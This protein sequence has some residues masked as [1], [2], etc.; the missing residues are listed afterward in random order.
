[1]FKSYLA[2]QGKPDRRGYL[3]VRKA[4]LLG[5]Q[6]GAAA[7][8][9]VSFTPSFARRSMFGVLKM[10]PTL[11]GIIQRAFKGMRMRNS[12]LILIF[13]SLF[14]LKYFDFFYLFSRR[15]MIFF[16]FS[17]NNSYLDKFQANHSLFFPKSNEGSLQN[18]SHCSWRRELMPWGWCYLEGWAMQSLITRLSETCLLVPAGWDSEIFAGCWEC[19]HQVWFCSEK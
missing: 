18:A 4:A 15:G 14:Y 13:G 2:V 19:S 5:V 12:T 1:M 9:W 11:S 6:S 7:M 8:C 16:L 3:P 10:Q 17:F